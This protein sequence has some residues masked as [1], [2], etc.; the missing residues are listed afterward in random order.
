MG[1]LKNLFNNFMKLSRPVYSFVDNQL[2]FKINSDFF[3]KYTLDD[4]DIKTRHDPY[5]LEA[6]TLASGDIF[7]EYIRDDFNTSWNGQ[8]LSLYEGFFK[9]KLKINTFEVKESIELD[10]YVFKTFLVDDSFILHLIYIYD[11]SS[12]VIIIDTKGQ[13]YKDLLR[14]LKDNYTYKFEDEVKGEINFNISIVKENSIK[15]YFNASD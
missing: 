9:E 10:S 6:Y 2:Q 3:Y 15:G 1:F 5:I 11:V 4:Y 14:S 13:L 12:N 8:A 7:L